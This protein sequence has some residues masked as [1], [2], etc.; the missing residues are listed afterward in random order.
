MLRLA[1]RTLWPTLQLWRANECALADMLRVVGEAA[2]VYVCVCVGVDGW[3]G[4]WMDEWGWVRVRVSV[5]GVVEFLNG[6]EKEFFIKRVQEGGWG[7]SGGW[8]TNE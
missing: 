2:Q 1:P 5:R 7:G 6:C 3:M 4:R 8:V